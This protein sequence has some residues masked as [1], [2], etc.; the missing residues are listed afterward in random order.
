M[1][2]LSSFHPIFQFFSPSGSTTDATS[3]FA[4]L[5]GISICFLFLTFL[6]HSRLNDERPSFMP[7]NKS[8]PSLRIQKE[9]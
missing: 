2:S 9:N 3:T 4:I 8:L 5:Y 6:H 7:K 1:A